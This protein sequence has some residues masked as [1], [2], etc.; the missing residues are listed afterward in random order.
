MITGFISDVLPVWLDR[1]E[2]LVRESGIFHLVLWLWALFQESCFYRICRNAYGAVR[3]VMLNSNLGTQITTDQPETSLM[4]GSMVISLLNRLLAFLPKI[5]AKLIPLAQGSG[6]ITFAQRQLAKIGTFGPEHAIGAV[7]LLMFI[8]PGDLWRN[9]FGLLFAFALLFVRFC[10]AAAQGKPLLRIQQIGFPLLIFM[11]AT[12]LGVAGAGD[13]GEALRVFTFYLAAFLFCLVL[14][15]E[16]DTEKKLRTI[17]AFLYA[18][19]VIGGVYA[20][21]QRI[22]GVP[23]DP[24]LTDISLNADMPGRVYS[25]FENPNNYAE[26]IVLLLPVCAAWA[27]TLKDKHK[28]FYAY[29]GLAFPVA[30]LLM[31]YSRSS[32]MGIALA[33]AVYVFVEKKQVLPALFLLGIAAIP[34]LPSSILNRILTIGTTT[35]TSSKYRIYVWTGVL[36]MLHNCA[37][38]GAGLGPGNFKPLFDEAC[39][40][41]YFTAAHAHMVYLEVWVEMGILGLVGYLSYT[42]TTIRTSIRTGVRNNGFLRYFLIAGASSLVG[43]AL[44]ACFEYVIFYPRVMYA[45]FILTGLLAAAS[46]LPRQPALEE[47]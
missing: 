5:G 24:S 1:L 40:T 38:F 25:F 47:A 43:I 37:I 35:D 30:A 18:A 8:I 41:Q 32:W 6:L 16:I 3:R 46:R 13:V 27:F 23:V 10:S 11:A 12:V 14:L 29:I 34:M 17:L 15:G 2:E 45:L 39:H 22:Q 20:V 19:L 33:A 4:E 31:T 9:A 44:V 26:T 7:F 42:F 21:I 36:D 28:R